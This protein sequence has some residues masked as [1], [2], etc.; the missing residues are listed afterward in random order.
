MR[1]GLASLPTAV[2]ALV[3]VGCAPSI[4][5]GVYVCDAD[6][7]CPPE[8][9]CQAGLCFAGACRRFNCADRLAE[10]GTIDDGCGGTIDCGGCGAG[11]RCDTN[12]CGCA[13]SGCD[14]RCGRV[15]DGCGG[16]IDC[17][18]CGPEETCGG[19]GVPD[20][21]GV[22]LCTPTS[23]AAQGFDCGVASDGCGT[24]LECGECAPPAECGAVEANLCG[25]RP[26][27]TCDQVPE[28]CGPVDDGCGGTLDC[29]GCAN[30]A[31]CE[32]GA[33]CADPCASADACGAIFDECR[34]T[35]VVCSC[36][37][38]DAN[39][40][41]NDV[42]V[43]LGPIAPGVTA[44]EASSNIY[45]ASGRADTD[46]YLYDIQWTGAVEEGGTR[47]TAR[48]SDLP[49]GQTRQLTIHPS[50]C[51]DGS[52]ATFL[53]SGDGVSMSAAG[54]TVTS[55]EARIEIELLRACQMTRAIVAVTGPPG[56]PLAE[57][58]PYRLEVEVRSMAVS[59]PGSP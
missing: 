19:G 49:S 11:E 41:A 54:C 39:E 2:L 6:A 16:T 20:V 47:V 42:G 38:E 32:A 9:T 31:A 45:K 56:P 36:C 24:I 14:G 55:T 34:G 25:C 57:C 22:G 51:V 13:A 46:R 7:D 8:M 48:I 4:P 33:C 17:G 18:G 1:H 35:M 27:T 23:C 58:P 44:V 21:C 52:T 29:G 5:S 15:P 10:C 43:E 53:C 30:G 40:P 12:R 3:A 26:F 59:V 28:E 50:A 37:R